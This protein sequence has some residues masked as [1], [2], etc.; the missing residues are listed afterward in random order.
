MLRFG[1]PGFHWFGSWVRTW[2]RSSGLAEAASHMPQLEGPATKTTQLCTG[3]LR[4]EKGKIK[5]L[6]RFL[7]L[8]LLCLFPTEILILSHLLPSSW[9]FPC[10]V[11]S[12]LSSETEDFGFLFNRTLIKAKP[13]AG[14]F[15]RSRR[16][17][18]QPEK[19]QS[20]QREALE[21]SE[22]ELRGGLNFSKLL[23]PFGGE[24]RRIRGLSSLTPLLE[25]AWDFTTTKPRLQCTVGMPI[26]VNS[27]AKEK[28]DPLADLETKAQECGS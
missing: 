28:T 19:R 23:F 7:L 24:K 1:S 4:G 9:Y 15:P 18:L 14:C 10:Q 13:A 22:M 16:R 17:G 6:K 5:S 2:H 27:V 20:F 3:R 12:L 26:S 21:G 25:P 8:P 11:Y